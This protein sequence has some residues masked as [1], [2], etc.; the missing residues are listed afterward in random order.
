V[1]QPQGCWRARLQRQTAG[2][3]ATGA[4]QALLTLL[5]TPPTDTVALALALGERQ[6]LAARL[7]AVRGPQDVADTRRRRWRTA[8]R[9]Q[10]RQGRAPRRALAAWPLFG[11]HVPVE[12]LTLREVLVRGR[13][14]GQSERLCKVWQSHGR[15]DASRR[16]TPWRIL[17]E[18]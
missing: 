10:G 14:R 13:M 6:R 5:E 17:G 15:V 7:W 16:T 18:V 9:D 12:R 4:R 8:A 2:Y 3:D 1:A 11:T